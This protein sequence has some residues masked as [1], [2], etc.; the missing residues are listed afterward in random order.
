MIYRSRG[1]PIKKNTSASGRD[2][3][4]DKN[5]RSA[6]LRAVKDMTGRS[7]RNQSPARSSPSE[8]TSSA[9]SSGAQTPVEQSLSPS[10]VSEQKMRKTTK[11]TLEE[12][13][14]TKDMMVRNS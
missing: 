14:S 7:S 8:D 12:F 5:D 3:R 6:A 9:P 11:S 13:F 10:P 2:R 4:D 1:T